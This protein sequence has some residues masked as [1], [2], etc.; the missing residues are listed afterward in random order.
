M[1]IGFIFPGQGSQYVGMGKDL[2]QNFNEVK[3]VFDEAEAVLEFP[4]KKICFDGP[5]SELRQTRYTQPAIFVHSIATLTLLKS[6]NINPA[7]TA[8]HSLGEYSALVAAGAISLTDGMRIVR[9]RAEEMQ[10]SGEKNPGTMAA[11]IGLAP[12]DI[13]NLCQD[14]STE[15]V[16]KAANFNSPGQIVISG[17][18]AGVHKAMELAKLKKARLVTELV[19]SGA[20]HSP[21]MQDALDG[22][23][24]ALDKLEIK[25]PAV[26]VYPN[27]TARPTKNP[28]ELRDLLK[29]Q[30]LSPVLWQDTIQ[31][32]ISDGINIFYEIGPGKVL[33][34]LVKRIDATA[35]CFSIGKTEDLQLLG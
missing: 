31:N 9:L 25:N 12:E 23:T 8:G 5:E 20:F 13:E 24:A 17:S 15:G 18:I 21:L 6:R 32:M 4:L 7:V 1:T 28:A 16:V 33:Q 22:L 2:Y 35:K 29:Q 11:I 19:V 30:L 3:Q 27:V 14:A 26:P 34:N 10:K